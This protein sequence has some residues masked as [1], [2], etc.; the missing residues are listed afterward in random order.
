MRPQSLPTDPEEIVCHDPATGEETGRAPIG[1][2]DDVRQAVQSARQAQP[3]WSKLSYRERARF[4]LNARELVLAEMD[5]IARLISRETGKPVP[6]AT[7]M[8]VVPTLD[9]MFFFAKN[10][11]KLLNPNSI[12]IALYN[13][14]G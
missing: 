2:A 12:N 11:K 1:S 10:T 9:L 7:S 8:E 13:L 4:V 14:M 3:S 6:E 5:D